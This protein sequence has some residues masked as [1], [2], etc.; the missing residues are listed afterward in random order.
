MI[1]LNE[2]SLTW[3]SRPRLTVRCRF[4]RHPFWRRKFIESMNKENF[5][6]LSIN[7]NNNFQL[8]ILQLNSLCL[9]NDTNWS[10]EW[11]R[12]PK[13]LGASTYWLVIVRFLLLAWNIASFYTES[14]M[15]LSTWRTILSQWSTRINLIYFIDRYRPLIPLQTRFKSF[16][17]DDHILWRVKLST[18]R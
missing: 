6:K 14:I 3:I 2:S 16:F 11:P 15:N 17:N 13:Q 8:N 9:S 1:R 10:M 7:S 18:I 4:S 5:L 12:P